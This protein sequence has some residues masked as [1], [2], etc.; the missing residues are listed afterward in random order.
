MQTIR[1]GITALVAGLLLSSVSLAPSWALSPTGESDGAALYQAYCAHCHEGQVKRA[2]QRDVMARLPA[3]T[4]LNSLERGRMKFLG[5]M[6]TDQERQ[7][8]SEWLTGKTLPPPT[9]TDETVAGFCADAPGT[10]AVEDGAPEWNGWGA[11]PFNTRFQPAA[12]AGI[13]AA[14]VPELKVKW[15]FGLPMDFR[16]S[17]P[18]VVGGRVFYRF[19]QGP[20]LFARC[21][22]RLLVLVGENGQW[23]TRD[24]GG[25]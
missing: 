3:S 4:V 2:P 6:R 24:P 14:Q 23:G 1:A 9:D 19:A 12:A 16:V 11:D 13:S 17:Q 10:F 7:A 25:R 15:V 5:M 21:Q 8:I 20:Y 22:N 18:T